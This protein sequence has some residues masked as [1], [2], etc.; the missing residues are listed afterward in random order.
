MMPEPEYGN[1]T[2]AQLAEEIRYAQSWEDPATVTEGLRIDASSHVLAIASSGDNALA[3][4]LRDAA[5]VTAVDMSAAQIAL[6]ELKVR[7][8]EYFPHRACMRFLGVLPADDRLRLY[9]ELQPRLSDVA[10]AYWNRRPGDIRKGVIHCGK[11]ERYF[12]LFRRAMLPLMQ[13]R[14]TVEALLSCASTAEQEQVYDAGWDNPRWRA[15]FRV[16]FSRLLLGR[17]GRDH[18]FFA[19]VTRGDIAD[20]LLRRTRRG[21]T[22][23]PVADNYFVHYILTGR[24]REPSQAHPWM[25]PAVFAQ[26]RERSSRLRCR[27]GRMGEETPADGHAPTALYCSDIFEYMPEEIAVALLRSLTDAAAPGARLLYYTLF[28]PRTLP[29]F[30]IPDDDTAATLFGRDRTF[31]YG[32]LGIGRV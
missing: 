5:S 11:F 26:L 2:D 21:L 31:F 6:L 22:E 19:Q 25:H 10:R 8:M 9:S 17:L 12:A 32:S 3:M 20:E 27:V 28:V 24:F 15:M 14:R 29:D 16:F 23:V 30:L 13:S 18:S 1:V 4:L 7:A